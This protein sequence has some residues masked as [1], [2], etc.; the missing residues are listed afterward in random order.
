MVAEPPYKCADGGGEILPAR[1]RKRIE[2]PKRVS[3][4]AEPAAAIR[5]LRDLVMQLFGIHAPNILGGVSACYAFE[6]A[7]CVR[8][9]VHRVVSAV[10]AVG[11]PYTVHN[12]RGD[13]THAYVAFAARLAHYKPCQQFQFVHSK[14]PFVLLLICVYAHGKYLVHCRQS[15]GGVPNKKLTDKILSVSFF[16]IPL[17]LNFI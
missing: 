5:P 14:S 9:V 7:R 3:H 15:G 16:H 10:F 4:H 6:L 1:W 2:K 13:G 12:Y 11:R 17:G 8:N